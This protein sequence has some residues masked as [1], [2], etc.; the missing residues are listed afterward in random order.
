MDSSLSDALQR[1]IGPGFRVGRELGGGGMSRV[2]LATELSLE[3]QVVIKVLSPELAKGVSAERF[4][5]EIQLVAR[6]QHPHVVPILSAGDADGA[7]YYVMPFL[8][9]ESLRARITRE[10]QLSVRDA[11]HVLR[12]TLDALSFAHAHDV[13][14]RDIKPENILSGAGHVVIADFG[15]SKALRDSGTMTTAGMAIGTPTYMAPEQI[16]CDPGSAEERNTRRGPRSAATHWTRFAGLVTS[17]SRRSSTAA[18][19]TPWRTSRTEGAASRNRRAQ[20]ARD[21]A[22]S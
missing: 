22:A 21:V 15:V 18:P 16:A 3:R 4:R 7:L 14:H 1:S 9:G 12:E 5:R 17:E 19:G 10:G 20:I 6:L 13:V 11:V 2:F 8:S